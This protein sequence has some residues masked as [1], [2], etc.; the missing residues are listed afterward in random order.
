MY[1]PFPLDKSRI[2]KTLHTSHPTGPIPVLRTFADEAQ[3]AAFIAIEIKRLVAGGGG[4]LGWDDFVI[5]RKF[6]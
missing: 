5:L 1:K 2:P 3:E 6:D 4:M